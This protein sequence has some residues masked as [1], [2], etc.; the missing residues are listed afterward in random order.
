MSADFDN[1]FRVAEAL[2]GHSR[3]TLPYRLAIVGY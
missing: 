1:T 3:F 2:F